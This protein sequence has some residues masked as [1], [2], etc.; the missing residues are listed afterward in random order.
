MLQKHFKKIEKDYLEM[1]YEVD[2][3]GARLRKSGVVLNKSRVFYDRE[4]REEKEK[5]VEKALR[6]MKK[7][8]GKS[9]VIA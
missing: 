2:T 5:S 7:G 4:G 3:L 8:F 1:K 9:R 6:K